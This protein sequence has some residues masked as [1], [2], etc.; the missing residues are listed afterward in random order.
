M[1]V[2]QV[3][4]FGKHAKMV[5]ATVKT[6]VEKLKLLMDIMDWKTRKVVFDAVI[7]SSLTYCLSVWGW[8]LDCRKIAQKSMS[9]ALRLLTGGTRYTRIEDMLT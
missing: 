3:Y 6:K 9:S 2:S 8:R 1:T 7:L 4:G 5:V